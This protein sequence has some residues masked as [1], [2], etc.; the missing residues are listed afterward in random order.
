MSMLI[1][2]LQK[3]ADMVTK[4]AENSGLKLSTKK[5]QLFS[6]EERRGK[7]S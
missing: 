7:G 4:W 1:E 2:G 5:T 3:D 6:L